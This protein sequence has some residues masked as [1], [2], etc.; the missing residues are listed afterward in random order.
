MSNEIQCLVVV[1][2]PL[3]LTL[4][5][6]LKHCWDGVPCLYDLPNSTTLAQQVVP[7]SVLPI[8]EIFTIENHNLDG[9]FL[10]VVFWSQSRLRTTSDLTHCDTN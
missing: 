7:H 4:D 6:I 2:I 5:C 1:L 9:A 8:T 10:H 3:Q